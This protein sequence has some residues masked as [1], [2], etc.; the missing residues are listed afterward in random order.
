MYTNL[1]GYF[2]IELMSIHVILYCSD[3]FRGERKITSLV[4]NLQSPTAS[5]A[6]IVVKGYRHKFFSTLKLLGN[7]T[8][9]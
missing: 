5:G 2:C 7:M 4:L 8:Q 3:L 6:G 9:A 1:C